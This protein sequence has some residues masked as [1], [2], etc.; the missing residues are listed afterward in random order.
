LVP[1]LGGNPQRSII[2]T[3][4]RSGSTFLG[5]VLNS[6]PGNYYHYEPL[7]DFGI[8]QVRGPPLANK[9]VHN[10]RQLLNCNYSD[11]G[12]YLQFGQDHN[13]L[14]QHNTRLWDRCTEYQHLCW[15]PQFL[16]K[17][18]ALFPFQSMKIVRLRLN[19]MEQLLEDPKLGIRVL[20][21]VRD[22]R[23]TMQ[24]RR[25]REWCPGQSDCWDPALLCADLIADYSTAIRLKK[26]FPN[27]F[28]VVRYEDVS[29]DPYKRVKEI[30][31]FFGF[32]LVP[33]VKRFLDTHTKTDA[34]GV[35][36]T[37]RNSRVAPF[38]WRSELSHK[39]VKL[40]QRKCSAAM[41]AWG[42]LNAHNVTHQ[43]TF[44][45]LSKKLSIG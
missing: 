20:L 30:L 25:H 8:V 44:R 34:G 6:I 45:S 22:P 38:R 33:T 41:A 27:Q 16:N 37:F 21:L 3:T 1:E 15:A 5:D 26:R 14:F 11:L 36:S 19:L 12:E 7:L 39:E 31:N 24:S 2:I 23:G 28:R 29:L 13:W 40:I 10:I 4:W 9:A 35:S 32:D 43:K 18:C 42:Y 17:Y